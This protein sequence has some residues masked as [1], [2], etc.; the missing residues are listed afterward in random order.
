MANTK[1]QESMAELD[2][3][4]AGLGTQDGSQDDESPSN[5][6]YDATGLGLAMANDHGINLADVTGTGKDGRITVP[7]VEKVIKARDAE[8]AEAE[9]QAE[10][11]ESAEAPEF[12]EA[13]ARAVPVESS[14]VVEEAAEAEAQTK[15][16][17]KANGDDKPADPPRKPRQKRRS[18]VGKQSVPFATTLPLH[19][20]YVEIRH[21]KRTL[22]EFGFGWEGQ[23]IV[24][25]EAA[26]ENLGKLLQKGFVPIHIE[27]LGLIFQGGV[28]VLWIFGLPEMDE[29]E[30]P[31]YNEIYHRIEL[32]G[33]KG[34]D[35]KGV[36][37]FDADAMATS[38]LQ[39]GWDLAYVGVVDKS[40][41]GVNVMWIFVR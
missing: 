22:N 10:A 40:D 11:D 13:E 15:D 1:A 18:K 37:G 12:A 7:D 20:S 24:T 26:D 32:V 19:T 4:L 3:T 31:R 8:I 27:S 34:P 5:A 28:Q 21:I 33:G 25:G 17:D 6:E 39:T 2:A 29:D 14:E 41:F 38:Y 36:S 16:S 9:A 30:A 23:E 35:G